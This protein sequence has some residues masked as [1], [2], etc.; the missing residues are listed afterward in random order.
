MATTTKNRFKLSDDTLNT[1]G[2]RM[3]TSGGDLEQFIKNPV[4]LYDHDEDDHL[5]IGRWENITVETDGIYADA[6]FDLKDTFAAQIS[7][8]VDDGFIKMA[9]ICAVPIEVS[10][11]PSVMLPGQKLP[12]VTKWRAREA[13]VTPIGSNHNSLQLMDEDG[14][15]IELN[16]KSLVKL[17][18]KHKPEL[19]ITNTPMKKVLFALKLSDTSSEDDAVSALSALE[20]RA[21]QAEIKLADIEKKVKE[22]RKAEALT[23]V[24]AAITEQRLDA[25]AK[26]STLEL[27]DKNFDAAKIMLSAIPKRVTAKTVVGNASTT[28][29]KMLDMSWDDL[30]KSG[31][32][33]Q[34]KDKF[35]DVYA[36]KY[37]EKFGV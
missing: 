2:F 6:V 27:F 9:S 1:F 8:K 32:L 21:T 5:P 12:T 19:L 14:N 35:P 10:D 18:D 22:A 4:M 36:E 33:I 30:D 16:E 11:D 23:L 37:K 13:S 20:Q 7:Q 3:L 29:E 31:K 24:N 26:E 15:K 17:F 28:E 25:S 34:L